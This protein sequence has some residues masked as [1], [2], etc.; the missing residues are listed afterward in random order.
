MVIV[1]DCEKI[2]IAGEKT[3][4][5]KNANDLWRSETRNRLLLENS[6]LGIGYYDLNGRILKLNREAAKSLGGNASDYI[7]KSLTDIYGKE[8]G[9]IFINRLNFTATSAYSLKYEDCV[10]HSGG[11]KWYHSTYTG[12][13]DMDGNVDSVQVITDNITD[14]KLCEKRLKE[15][16]KK[17]HKLAGHMEQIMETERSEVALNLHDD[18][19]QKLTAMKMNIAWVKGRIGVQSQ[20]VM[21]KLEDM[22]LMIN[23]TIENIKEISSFLRPII[24]FDL[25]LV[26]A[27]SSLLNKFEKQSG[28][29]CD[30]NYEREEFQISDR[31][32]L[33]LYRV[34]QESLTNITRHSQASFTEVNLRLVK[35]NIELKIADNGK[36][37]SKNEIN[38]LKSMGIAGIR[39]RVS[40]VSGRLLIKG[41]KNSGTSI[42]VSIPIK[43]GNKYD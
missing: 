22:N 9:E 4:S 32:S 19:G 33:I 43:N 10:K 34:L 12:I 23:D 8:Y 15:S 11:E 20:L 17:L 16:Q 2:L 39:E 7:G 24:L 37:I 5:L 29:R 36:G 26:P 1:D 14:L 6:G 40:S 30:F 18:L 41:D 13:P 38:S 35:D 25:G 28:I 3:G 42:K 21:E 27:F 31:V